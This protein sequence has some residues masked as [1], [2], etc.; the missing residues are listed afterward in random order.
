MAQYPFGESLAQHHG[1][2]TTLVMPE[3]GGKMTWSQA[4]RTATRHRIRS[5]KRRKLAKRLLKVTFTQGLSY[6]LNDSE[7]EAL[8]GLLNRRGYN[9]I[10]TEIDRRPLETVPPSWIAN[11]FPEFFVSSIAISE[12]L[13]ELNKLYKSGALTEDEFSN[14]KKKVLNQ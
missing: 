9:R 3:E 1:K 10:E 14:A 8:N 12:Q 11:E 13:E 6:K 4:G 7:L 5:N 2:L